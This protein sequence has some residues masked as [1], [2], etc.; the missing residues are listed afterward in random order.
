MGDGI[1]LLELARN[2]SRLFVKQPSHEKKGLLNLMLSN[3]K[4]DQGWFAPLSG[5][6]LIYFRKQS[7]RQRRQTPRIR[8]YRQSIQ[9]GWGA[10]IRTR[11]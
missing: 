11:E 10:W 8:S 9:F 1:R 7:Y 6:R 5:S 4:W 3:C 2:A